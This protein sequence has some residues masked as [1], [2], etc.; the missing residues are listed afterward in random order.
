MTITSEFDVQDHVYTLINNKPV[1]CIVRKVEF[2]TLMFP[3]NEKGEDWRIIY[4]LVT[5][6]EED[7]RRKS[8]RSILESNYEFTRKAEEVAKSPKALLMRMIEKYQPKK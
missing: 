1:E 2:P 8:G 6:E 7:D 4:T 5:K 3:P